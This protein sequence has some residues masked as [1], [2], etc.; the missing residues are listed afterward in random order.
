M[1]DSPGKRRRRDVKAKKAAAFEERRLAR[2]R[3]REDRTAGLIDT[4]APIA[5]AEEDAHARSAPADQGR[6]AP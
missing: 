3:R 1:P 2:T 5:A 4:G 6:K